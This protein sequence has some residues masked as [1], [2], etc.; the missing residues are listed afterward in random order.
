MTS[1]PRLAGVVAVAGLLLSAPAPAS[2]EEIHCGDLDA[3]AV[4][5][6]DSPSRPYAQMGVAQAQAEGT[7]AGVTVAL[8]D[9]GVATGNP[10]LPDVRRVQVAG[11]AD[12]QDDPTLVAGLVAGRSRADRLQP[13]GMAPG[14]RI[15]SITVPDGDLTAGAAGQPLTADHVAAGIV[16]A[17]EA[18]ADVI[19]VSSPTQASDALATAVRDALDEG[20]VMVAAV[21]E[22]PLDGQPGFEEYGAYE[23]GENVQSYPAAYPGVLG[24]GT[25]SADGPPELG[26]QVVSDAIDVVAPVVGSVSTTVNGSTCVIDGRTTGLAAG[27]VAGLAALLVGKYDAYNPAQ[28]AA[29][30]META[31][32]TTDDR[33]PLDGFG[34]IQPTEAMT[35]QLR[36]EPDGTVLQAEQQVVEATPVAPP[37]EGD[38]PFPGMRSS[39]M[40]WGL[41]AGGG[42]LLA[43]LLRPLL[44]R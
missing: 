28:V 24:V 37:G 43:L 11:V 13:L 19:V 26:T 7:G 32:G 22:R 21:G 25:G 33:S 6:T 8:I 18:G 30:I 29:V 44:R 41:L 34:T 10:W 4:Q 3:E 40:W 9:A 12:A 17:V 31:S 20:V 27:E 1:V 36:I 42:L 35:R 5:Q 23:A 38:D 2:A 14:A 15:V 16:S 39:L